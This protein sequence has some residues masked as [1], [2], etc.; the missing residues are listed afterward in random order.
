MR[1][2]LELTMEELARVASL[3]VDMRKEPIVLLTE[4][5]KEYISKGLKIEAIKAVR[6]RTGVPLKE[7][8]D[9]VEAN[10]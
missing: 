5:E 6:N 9:I 4:I 1:I 3:L 2:E 10:T 7:A 8:K